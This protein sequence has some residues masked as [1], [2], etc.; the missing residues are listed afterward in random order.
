LYRENLEG[1]SIVFCPE[2]IHLEESLLLD[3]YLADASPQAIV[4][5]S[6][7][8]LADELKLDNRIDGVIETLETGEF[9]LANH[10]FLISLILY[11]I[12]SLVPHNPCNLA[13]LVLF[14]IA[15]NSVSGFIQGLDIFKQL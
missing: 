6:S 15:S 5:V 9:N 14:V 2:V 11:K 8:V 12:K 7:K 3:L 4:I 1:I 13:D 10:L